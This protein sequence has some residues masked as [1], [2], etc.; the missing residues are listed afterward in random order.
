MLVHPVRTATAPR[1][2]H[3]RQP[4]FLADLDR[5]MRRLGA[6][7]T[8]E[9]RALRRA[10]SRE[11]AKPWFFALLVGAAAGFVVLGIGGR[12]AMRA[13]AI[14]SNAPPSF[15]LDGTFTV[16]LLGLLTGVGGGLLYAVLHRLIPQ[17]RMLRSA[18]YGFVIVLLTLRGLRPIQPFAL[19][20]FMPLTLSYGIVVDML[21]TRWAS[22]R[23]TGPPRDHAQ[24]VSYSGGA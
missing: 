18:L 2:Q 21:F 23:S 10:I 8:S 20:W 19:E 6:P 15:T 22:R 1:G 17:R 12:I 16:I 14:A 9:A 24:S 13:I 11:R 5:Q 3:D 7:V 4:R